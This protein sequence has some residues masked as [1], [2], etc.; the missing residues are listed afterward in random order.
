MT[1]AEYLMVDLL[2]F[3]KFKTKVFCFC[4]FSS[5]SVTIILTE[6]ITKP[7]ILILY[8][9]TIWDFLK[10]MAKAQ[11]V[12]QAHCF[13]YVFFTY[14]KS[15]SFSKEVINITTQGYIFKM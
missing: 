13:V 8:V 12:V 15:V 14:W 11:L 6:S 7:K 10:F 9:G 4:F 1:L 5:V 2:T 3:S